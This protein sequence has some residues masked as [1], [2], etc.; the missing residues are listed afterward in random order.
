[1]E[2]NAVGQ[3]FVTQRHQTK[4][5]KS[6]PNFTGK[7]DVAQEITNSLYHKGA[8]SFMKKLE[9]LK[10]ELGGILI[11]ALGTGL[12]APIFI[13][14]NPFVKAPK[15][16][17]PE[18]KEDMKNT[19]LYTAMRQPISAALAILFQASVQKYIDKG[20]DAL[21][22]VPE[23]ANKMRR[24]INQSDL[25]TD[26]FIKA[27]VQK[28]LKSEGVTKPS[29][30]EA[31]FSGKQGFAARAEY[32]KTVKQRVAA[33]KESQMQK[34]ADEFALTGKI[35]A[36]DGFMDNETVAKLVNEQIDNYIKDARSLQKTPEQITRYLERADVLM[37][38]EEY[39]K[40]IFKDIPVEQ[41]KNAK[42]G[43]P[44]LKALYKQTETQ[45]KD[46]LAKETN[47]EV[48]KLLQEL[49]D[50]P[51]DLRI[52]RIERT[53]ARIDS[54]KA[55]CKD[56]YTKQRYQNALIERKNVLEERLVKLF[57]T[58]IKDPAAATPETI[59][60]AIANAVKYC[61]FTHDNGVVESVLKNTDTFSHDKE[62]LGKKVVKDVIKG[63]KK[64]IDNSFKSLNQ[65]TKIAVGVLITLPI[66]C[67]A[68][69]WVYP[70]F[71]EL[72]FPKLAGTKKDKAENAQQ[73]G[74]DK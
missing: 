29:L 34:I 11:T 53:F 6:Q 32:D 54:I 33:I 44:E 30:I 40:E 45:I 31:L 69:N 10:G 14:F 61:N 46:L 37:R 16:A 20:L 68:L 63:Y 9:F 24:D 59:K 43:S 48:K 39:L 38:N 21:F 19:K 25:N 66:T 2:I 18:Q 42:E 70:R 22:N 55:M 71:M 72:F 3:N 7:L 35:K 47:P 58:K 60:E 26:T 4:G 51:E 49:L 15:D 64:L 73:A 36:G 57:G 52:H 17:T 74:G 56:G 67:T 13:G 28:Q 27:N 5:N 65:I 12:V 8:I 23:R 50:R 41:A 62:A 1:M